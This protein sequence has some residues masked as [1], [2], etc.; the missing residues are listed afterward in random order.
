MRKWALPLLAL[1][2]VPFVA[3]Q[4]TLSPLDSLNLNGFKIPAELNKSIKAEKAKPGDRLEFRIA[5]PILAGKGM[6]IPK[7]AKLYGSVLRAVA[8][9]DGRDSRLSIVMERAEWKGH[10]LALRAFITG[11][12]RRQRRQKTGLDC[13]PQQSAPSFRSRKSPLPMSSSPDSSLDPCGDYNMDQEDPTAHAMDL[14]IASIQLYKNNIDGHTVL[15]SKKN[16][17]LPAGMLLMF[18][19]ETEPETTARK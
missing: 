6:V 9:E 7:D 18:S 15:V 11:W 1:L 19:N 8:A 10:V 17:H 4:E 3:A 12:G 13:M 16:I 2:L 14:L 5:E